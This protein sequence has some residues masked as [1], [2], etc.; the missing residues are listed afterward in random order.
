METSRYARKLDLTELNAHTYGVLLTPPGSLVLDVGTADGGVAAGLVARG[1][2]VHGLEVN[3]EWA[4]QAA[5]VTERMVV[6]DVE[7]L[8]LS[9][10]FGG[11]RYDVVLCLDVLEHLLE[12]V[13]TLRRLSELLAPGG[14][15]VAS[16]PNITHA[17]VRLQLLHGS[18]TYTETGL[19]D[20]THLRFFDRAGVDRLFQEAGLVI[21]EHLAVLRELHETEIPL[22]L[23]TFS[24]ESIKEASADPDA[25]VFQWIVVGMPVTAPVDHPLGITSALFERVRRLDEAQRQT[26]DYVR[27]LEAIIEQKSANELRLEREATR[28]VELEAVLRE[29]MD[30]LADLYE[31]LTA[32]QADVDVKSSYIQEL[33]RDLEFT[34]RSHRLMAPSGGHVSRRVVRRV[35]AALA[36][37]PR[38]RAAGRRSARLLPSGVSER[39]RH[40]VREPDRR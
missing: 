28:I 9:D 21:T 27:S 11:T 8:D 25:K 16:L 33:L 36:A 3:E 18:F 2:R 17:A 12:P 30:E 19:L 1:C 39:L 13:G 4:A 24:P 35:L 22:D 14:V 37:S 7:K 6:G 23:D 26:G 34:S 5:Q 15:V 38:I 20:R 10:A 31:R 29:R 40:A 32:S